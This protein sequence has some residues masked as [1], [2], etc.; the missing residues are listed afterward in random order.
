ME[1]PGAEM[2]GADDGR[3]TVGRLG[4]PYGVHGW[5][6]IHSYTSPREN[7]L[8]YTPWWARLGGEWRQIVPREGRPHGKGLVAAIEGVEDRESARALVGAE[9]AVERSAFEPPEAGQYYWADLIGLRV[10][11]GDGVELGVVDHLIDAGEHDVLVLAAE[12]ERMIPFVMG[13]T[14]L[15][16]DLGAGRLVADWE[17]D[18]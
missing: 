2:R 6:R 5:F 14:V 17:P 8:R 18:Y 7:I 16:V 9:I 13:R 4:A 12:R 15:E 1:R 10:V 3:V 11:N